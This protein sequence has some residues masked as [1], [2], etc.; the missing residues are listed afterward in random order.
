MSLG[1]IVS[2]LKVKTDPDGTPT[3][4]KG[5]ITLSDPA[6]ATVA[7]DSYSACADDITDRVITAVAQRL[8][9]QS[10]VADVGGAYFHGKPIPADQGGRELY[11][12]VPPWLSEFGNYPTHDSRGRAN[13]L[14]MQGNFPG[15]RDAGPNWQRVY[16]A[17]LLSYGMRQSVVDRRLVLLVRGVDILILYVHVDDT[18]LWFSS[19]SVR[20]AFLA[21]WALKFSEPPATAE[22]SEFF[23]GIRSQ[24]VDRFTTQMT[25]VGVI[26]SIQKLI[27]QHPLGAGR[28]A[29]FPMPADGPRIL[30]DSPPDEAPQ[31]AESISLARQIMGAVGFVATHV[32]PDAY[33]AFCCLARYMGPRLTKY[34]FKLVVRLAHYLVGTMHMPLVIHTDPP[35]G[36]VDGPLGLFDVFCDSSHGNAPDGHSFG[37]FVLMHNGGGALAWK[38]RNQAFPTDSPGAQELLVATL[39]YR[40]TLSLRML[41]ADLGLGVA[42]ARPTLMWTDSQILLD[43]TNCERLGKSSRWLSSRYAMMR[44]GEACGAIAPTKLAAEENVGNAMTKPETGSLFVAHRALLLGLAHAVGGEEGWGDSAELLPE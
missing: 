15:R 42:L 38:S 21:A 12:V 34:A 11:A 44:F 4:R 2:V 40:W 13:Y 31:A 6:S 43:G 1:F 29:D 35:G 39:A 30:R 23:V 24:R 26:K 27:S 3:S 37:G 19:P 8:G 17:F 5:R 28:R 14:F 41:L 16:D 36:G 25:C 9:L 32:R 20:T 7:V 10:D 22:F 33:F 18:K